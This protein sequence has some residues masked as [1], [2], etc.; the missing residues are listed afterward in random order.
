MSTDREADKNK[1]DK[2]IKISK[3]IEIARMKKLQRKS[4]LFCILLENDNRKK[5]KQKNELTI[6]IEK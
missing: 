4:Y 3:G 2:I 1:Q 6:E 5:S